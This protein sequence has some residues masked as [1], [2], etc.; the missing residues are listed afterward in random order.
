MQK[1]APHRG[2][3]H[4]ALYCPQLEMSVH[5]YTELLGMKVVWQ[6]DNDNIYLSAGDDNL[7]LHRAPAGFDASGQQRLDHLGF[8]LNEKSDVDAWHAFLKENG[9]T[10][11]TTPKDHRDGTRSFYCTDPDGNAVQM[12][13]YP[14]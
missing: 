8:F 5:F 3:R 6:P 1:P 4:L 7:A 2:L 9:V 11:K 13:Y 12:I 10:I 14:S